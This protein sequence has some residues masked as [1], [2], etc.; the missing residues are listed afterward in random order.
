MPVL[1]RRIRLTLLSREQAAMT[2]SISR[3]KLSGQIGL[4]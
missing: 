4:S 1:Q 3:K 2:E